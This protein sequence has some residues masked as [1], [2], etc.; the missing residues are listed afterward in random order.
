[1]AFKAI[2][3]IHQLGTANYINSDLP[4][5]STASISMFNLQWPFGVARMAGPHQNV[6]NKSSSGAPLK[7][8]GTAKL[9]PS[10]KKRA[11]ETIANISASKQARPVGEGRGGTPSSFLN[12]FSLHQK[13]A[14]EPFDPGMSVVESEELT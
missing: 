8:L 1:L 6:P 11:L 9:G 13:P 10:V 14:A 12:P 5:A 3:Q 4:P 2:V 7:P